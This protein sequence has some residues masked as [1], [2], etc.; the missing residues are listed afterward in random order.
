MQ[1]G[2]RGALLILVGRLRPSAGA[3]PP[4]FRKF[5]GED[6]GFGPLEFFL[7]EL[8]LIAPVGQF[9]PQIVAQIIGIDRRAG[10]LGMR[11]GDEEIPDQPRLDAGFSHAF[12][13]LHADARGVGEAIERFLLERVR[14]D[15]ELVADEGGWPIPPAD[16]LIAG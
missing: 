15:A 2:K 3:A 7:Q 16:E 11:A 5:L 1:A 10:D 13:G 9:G 14:L 12:A 6:T 8:G 4:G